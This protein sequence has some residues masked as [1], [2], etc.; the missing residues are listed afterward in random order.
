VPGN[1]ETPSEAQ[2]GVEVNPAP[3]VPQSQDPSPPD[4]LALTAPIPSVSAQSDAGDLA[5][6]ALARI[7]QGTPATLATP[8]DPFVFG[9]GAI[10]VTALVAAGAANTRRGRRW[11]AR[12]L[13]HW[14]TLTS[15]LRQLL[16]LK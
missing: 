10:A 3:A 6:V 8:L 11:V 12:Q 1:L 13:R 4:Q 14:S 15:V 7:D 5:E 9:A 16:G 2:P